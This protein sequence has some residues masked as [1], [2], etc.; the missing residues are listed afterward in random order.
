[1]Q[2]FEIQIDSL[3][4]VFELWDF[5]FSPDFDVRILDFLMP[6]TRLVPAWPG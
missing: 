1:M 4:G 6:Q 2:M 5:G 3:F